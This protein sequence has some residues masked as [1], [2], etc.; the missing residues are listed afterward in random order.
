[1]NARR[2]GII[3]DRPTDRKIFSKIAQCLL[4]ADDGETESPQIIELK[5]L[6]IRDDVDRYWR[7]VDKPQEYFLPSKPATKLLGDIMNT[8]LKAF[9]NFELEVGELSCRDV[10]LIT[11][12]AEKT[13]KSEEV[14]YSEV[15]AFSL[16]KICLGAVEKF[17]Q[18]KAKEFCPP[19]SIPLI[20][21]VIAFPSTEV[22]VSAAKGMTSNGKSARELKQAV[23]D[24]TNLKTLND[25][26]LAKKAL[27]YITPTTVEYIFRQRPESRLFIQHLS[28]GKPF[29]L[30]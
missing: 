27:N 8:I 22:F 25:G 3:G 19:S 1:M 18:A 12:D 11:S 28:F 21:P 7:T 26:E 24:T 15:W 20:V 30:G 2:V 16:S 13:L 5:R 14:Y 17:Y 10:L 29:A 6:N 4:R 9:F 23:Y